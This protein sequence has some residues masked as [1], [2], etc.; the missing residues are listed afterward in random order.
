VPNLVK[1]RTREGV[2][3]KWVKYNEIFIYLFTPFSGTHLPV[4]LVD[5]FSRLMAQRT[6]TRAKGVP[7]GGFVDTVPHFGGEIPE[8]SQNLGRE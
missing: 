8:N 4:R 7:F 6:R 3:G 5:G 1:I 2:L